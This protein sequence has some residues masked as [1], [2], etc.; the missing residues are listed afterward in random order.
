MAILGSVSRMLHET[1]RNDA[2]W[3]EF[4]VRAFLPTVRITPPTSRSSS[5][6]TTTTMSKVQRTHYLLSVIPRT[7]ADTNLSVYQ[8][9]SRKAQRR[10]FK[11]VP[12]VIGLGLYEPSLQ[13]FSSSSS[14]SLPLPLFNN[15]NITGTPLPST[16]SSPPGL[17]IVPGFTTTDDSISGMGSSLSTI[18]SHHNVSCSRGESID[19]QTLPVP[20]RIAAVEATFIGVGAMRFVHLSKHGI[21]LGCTDQGHLAAWSM[22]HIKQQ[23]LTNT[24]SKKETNSTTFS[25]IQSDIFAHAIGAKARRDAKRKYLGRNAQKESRLVYFKIKAANTK[26]GKNTPLS[27]SHALIH[28]KNSNTVPKNFD[29]DDDFDVWGDNNNY[30]N[31]NASSKVKETEKIVKGVIVSST[32]SSRNLSSGES[33]TRS[34]SLSEK[35]GSIQV[36]SQPSLSVEDDG[37]TSESTSTT[38]ATLP[39]H[40]TDNSS[41]NENTESFH[42]LDPSLNASNISH[43][44]IDH[45]E[46][47]GTSTND[48]HPLD[49]WEAPEKDNRRHYRKKSTGTDPGQSSNEDEELVDINNSRH[50]NGKSKRKGSDASDK[51][52]GKD[53]WSAADRA[54]Y[55]E[56]QAKWATKQ[57]VKMQNEKEKRLG[58][59]NTVSQSNSQ[60]SSPKSDSMAYGN[61]EASR[62]NSTVTQTS[63]S[64]THRSPLLSGRED[65]YTRSRSNSNHNEGK[66]SSNRK[67]DSIPSL[68]LP[69]IPSADQLAEA[70]SQQAAQY[71]IQNEWGITDESSIALNFDDPSLHTEVS[72]T[73]ISPHTVR[74]A[75]PLNRS[76]TYTSEENS[77][78]ESGIENTIDGS[79]SAFY[80]VGDYT[81][82]SMTK[83][84]SLG[85]KFEKQLRAKERR[86]DREAIKIAKR[87][88]ET[89]SPRAGT[90]NNNEVTGTTT[91][92]KGKSPLLQSSKFSPASPPLPPRS[93]SSGKTIINSGN[94]VAI[95]K[96][97]R[98]P[99]LLSIFTG[100]ENLDNLPMLSMTQRTQSNTSTTSTNSSNTKG[101]TINNTINSNP[102]SPIGKGLPA[103]SSGRN[104][105]D[106]LNVNSTSSRNS[107]PK[108]GSSKTAVTPSNNL[109]KPKG[110]QLRSD[111]WVTSHWIRH[112]IP[113]A[114]QRKLDNTVN[115]TNNVN[116]IGIS[117]SIPE[118]EP[119]PLGTGEAITYHALLA[120]GDGTLGVVAPQSISSRPNDVVVIGSN[121]GPI[122]GSAPSS[123]TP[124]L[125]PALYLHSFRS[126]T[127]SLSGMSSGGMNNNATYIDDSVR[128]LN[129]GMTWLERP[130]GE[131]KERITAATVCKGRHFLHRGN[132]VNTP[133]DNIFG[134]TTQPTIV[135]PTPSSF[136]SHLSNVSSTRDKFDF[137]SNNY[138]ILTD[139]E[140]DVIIAAFGRVVGVWLYNDRSSRKDRG[141][142]SNVPNNDESIHEREGAKSPGGTFT[143]ISKKALRKQQLLDD[144]VT[145]EHSENNPSSRTQSGSSISSQTSGTTVTDT[146][147]IE[148]IDYSLQPYTVFRG[149]SNVITSVYSWRKRLHT[150][151][152][153]PSYTPA[154]YGGS[155]GVTVLETGIIAVVSGDSQGELCLWHIHERSGLQLNGNTINGPKDNST[156]TRIA[157]LQLNSRKGIKEGI[158]CL[159]M[160]SDFI[161]AGGSEGTVT[162]WRRKF[163][164]SFSSSSIGNPVNNGKETETELI[165]DLLFRENRAH[166]IVRVV[167]VPGGRTQVSAILSGG[168]EGDVRLW[169]IPVISSSNPNPVM[170]ASSGSGISS[171]NQSGSI[172]NNNSLPLSVLAS[173]NT[174]IVTTSSAS[175]LTPSS[176]MISLP[177]SSSISNTILKECRLL[178]GHQ[179]RISG[180]YFNTTI[181]ITTS[182]DGNIKI[183]D[184]QA[185]HLGRLLHSSRVPYN[186]EISSLHC[187]GTDILVGTVEGHVYTLSFGTIS[188]GGN[189]SG[190]SSTSI[191]NTI[192]G[193]YFSPSSSSSG[194]MA[195][196]YSHYSNG[197][198]SD[199]NGNTLVGAFN[200]DIRMR[201]I[202][203][204]ISQ[205]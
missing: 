152:I 63:L 115:S 159:S 182:L 72:E 71:R 94:G 204:V 88:G 196:S 85:R 172:V 95:G 168:G 42:S 12:L 118:M 4:Y 49:A 199:G 188:K 133:V 3:G 129:R 112:E 141:T 153:A 192:N 93:T 84:S 89:V 179:S 185:P 165:P 68:T 116:N 73:V 10:L 144:T 35:F 121:Q 191:T 186:E 75:P 135:S 83:P 8:L 53:L 41:D 18:P 202:R 5:T 70:L 67:R 190:N 157:T 37:D 125:E 65:A 132:V 167:Q 57:Q 201:D 46:V 187:T 128:W 102:S 103:S 109:N 6:A 32:V 193:N 180:L 162:A 99:P 176:T 166:S 74:S 16:V 97:H 177:S 45:V 22:H 189:N 178:K 40:H 151:I 91:P 90:V 195:V 69:S 17:T 96:E 92:A 21:I 33:M 50:S 119:R 79:L 146:N 174:S 56:K 155:E 60:P 30:I 139:I 29:T 36:R 58:I 34:D 164:R 171:S 183:W 149:H 15:N 130:P 200:S 203:S 194:A 163:V 106:A 170:A 101:N 87:R 205:G 104:S 147:V 7:I 76:T 54:K 158:S 148:D 108:L 80:T 23:K 78:N 127:P 175:S 122:D 48:I 110:S 27:P 117:L 124:A 86:A 126:R 114:R 44:V 61:A 136:P 13:S 156:I 197:S 39:R 38:T 66:L 134:N 47:T 161:I 142:S 14:T 198:R 52:R 111:V 81:E 20:E 143:N 137:V 24:P 1:S 59:T 181:V 31:D 140:P 64:P 25:S 43:G 145:V 62:T 98:S 26:K 100:T 77:E 107:S 2:T 11:A 160:D 105:P 9:F 82:S 120:F 138:T 55:D 169:P 28:G 113:V 51:K 154:S 173:I 131:E 123:R 150:G 184:L 19:I